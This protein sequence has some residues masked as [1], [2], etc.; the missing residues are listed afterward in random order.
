MEEH[1]KTGRVEV[2]GLRAGMDRKT[3][4]KYL[5]GKKLPS[6]LCEERTYRTRADPFEADWPAIKAQIAAAPELEAKTI[7]EDLLD[8]RPGQ[9][10]PG[11]LRTLQRKIKSWRAEEGPEKEV[12][13]AQLHRPG[14]AAQTD[15]TDANELKITIAGA[16]FLHLLC[17]FV[18]PYSNWQCAT[19]CKSESMAAIKRGVQTAVFRLGRVPKFHQTDH[20]TSATHKLS[21][22]DKANAKRADGQSVPARGF[23]KEYVDFMEHLGMTPRTIAVGEK[24]Q[25]GDIEA[26]NGALKRRLNQ[27]L[28]LRGNRDFEDLSEYQ[29]FIDRTTAKMNAARVTRVREDLEQMSI[30]KVDRLVEFKEIDV[31]VTSWS[32]I[33]VKRNAYSVHSRLIGEQVRVRL[34]ED[35]L[36]VRYNG[37]LQLT[38]ERVLG[39]GGNLINYRHLIWSLVR[40]PGAFERYRYREALFPTIVF[41]RTYD[42]LC[43][44]LDSRK[45]TIEYLRVLKLAADTMESAVEGAL[46]KLLAAGKTPLADSIRGEV[47]PNNTK[48]PQLDEPEVNLVEFDELLGALGAELAEVL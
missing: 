1:S 43:A 24:E 47:A 19:I 7:F 30:L 23:N 8:R 48:V 25:N 20:S 33:R 29:Q 11:Q 9:F 34:Y 5:G 10:K 28:I 27:L 13:F 42:S 31:R 32:T 12:F 15:F 26:A 14:E 38:C 16:P 3:A 4:R 40:K 37:K 21:K 36:E 45:A 46:S 17:H 22:A 2:S 18:L 35:R 44:K 41:R 39:E 6:E